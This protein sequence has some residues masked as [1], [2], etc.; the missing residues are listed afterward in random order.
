MHLNKHGLEPIQPREFVHFDQEEL[1]LPILKAAC[2]THFNMPLGTCDVLVSNKGPSCTHISQIP[3]R[4]DKVILMNHYTCTRQA[5]H[6]KT[7]YYLRNA[8]IS[9]IVWIFV[10]SSSIIYNNFD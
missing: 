2:A 1:T 9:C 6:R 3:H 8:P 10:K 5:I 4:K 7:K